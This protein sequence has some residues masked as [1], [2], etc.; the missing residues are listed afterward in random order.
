MASGDGS[1]ARID[2]TA[3]EKRCPTVPVAIPRT[4]AVVAAS[5]SSTTRSTTTSRSRGG[6]RRSPARRRPPAPPPPQGPR[7]RGRRAAV[8][9]GA[10]ATTTPRCSRRSAPPTP[11]GR[12]DA[13]PSATPSTPWRTPPQPDPLPAADRQRLPSRPSDKR[14]GCPGTTPRSPADPVPHP[15]Y[16][17]ELLSI[18]MTG[19]NHT[20]SRSRGESPN[21]AI[22]DSCRGTE[23][24]RPGEASSGRHD[25]SRRKLAAWTYPRF[26]TR[27][28]AGSRSRTR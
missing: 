19:A 25:R 3:L 27:G 5:R 7:R 21:R 8:P 20:E 6:K 1:E 10:S 2:A 28:A 24:S 12:D 22:R 4:L 16:A 13:S 11:A 14:P 26:T 18:Y 23:R 15:V 9:G 17:H